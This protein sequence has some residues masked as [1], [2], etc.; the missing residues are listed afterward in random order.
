MRELGREHQTL[1]RG[2]VGAL[3]HADQA[4]G[5]C[6]LCGGRM[7]VQKT[8]EHGGAVVALSLANGSASQ[9]EDLAERMGSSTATTIAAP[10]Y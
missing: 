2:T 7:R 10:R 3:V 1:L 4:A 8:F 9:L 6:P 5:P